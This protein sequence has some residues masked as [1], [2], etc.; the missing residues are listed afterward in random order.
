MNNQDTP[1]RSLTLL[2]VGTTACNLACT[3]C[4][5]DDTVRSRLTADQFVQI[6]DKLDA[7]FDASTEFIIVF[8]GG[9]PLLLGQP[10]FRRAFAH[11]AGQ[12]RPIKT[13]IQTNLTLLTPDWIDLL[14]EAG[15]QIGTSVDGTEEMHDAHRLHKSGSGSYREVL[16]RIKQVTDRGVQCSAITTLNKANIQDPDLLYEGFRRYGA[17]AI[18]FSLVYGQ[19][20]AGESMLARGEMGKALNRLFDLWLADPDPVNLAFF[21]ELIRSVLGRPGSRTCRWAANCTDYFLAVRPDGDVYPCCDFVGRDDFCYGNIFDQDI[22]TIWGGQRRLSLA[23]RNETLLAHDRCGSCEIEGF[24][25]GGCMAKA[26]QPE[27]GRDYYCDDYRA[28]YRHVREVVL[29]LTP[30]RPA[31]AEGAAALVGASPGRGRP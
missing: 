28:V 31:D 17:T 30:G 11:L 25:H 27:N 15:C 22:A 16:D 18:Y 1:K 4:Y 2:I 13:A 9:E 19:G 8:H 23:A 12:R 10:F 20:S 21:G 26:A 6:Y 3:Y 24:C 14:S 5:V 29:A 7:Y